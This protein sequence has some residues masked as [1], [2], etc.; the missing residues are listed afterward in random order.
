[1]LFLPQSVYSSRT[2]LARDLEAGRLTAD[3]AYQQMLQL[4]PD[5][6][7]ALLGL[8]RLRRE[9]GDIAGAKEIFWQAART[10]PYVSSPYLALAKTFF[11]EPESLGLATALGE[12]GISHRV[13]DDSLLQDADYEKASL[14]GEALEKFKKLPGGAQNRLVVRAMREERAGEPEEIAKLLHPFRLLQQMREDGDLDRE[15]VDT[16]LREGPSLAPLLVGILRGWA[17]DLLGEKDDSA[18]ENALALLGETGSPANIPHL[19]EFVGLEH[20][21]ASGASFWALGRMFERY[22]EES[23]RVIRSIASGLGPAERLSIAE[24]IGR[25]PEFDPDGNL[26]AF[27]G[28]NLEAMPKKDRDSFFLALTATMAS[29]KGQNGVNLGR[30]LLLRQAALLSKNVRHECEDLLNEFTR[31]GFPTHT[32]QPS[33]ISVYDVCAGE[34]VWSADDEEEEKEFEGEFDNDDKL[35]PVLELVKRQALPARNEPCW[36]GSGKKYKKCHLD[37]DTAPPASSP[38]R[39]SSNAGSPT[40]FDSLRKRIGEFLGQALPRHD[41]ELAVKEMFNDGAPDQEATD[42]AVT[43]WILHDWVAPSLGHPIM[44]HFLVRNGARLTE[45]EREMVQAWAQSFMGLYEVQDLTE[46]VGIKI[47]DLILGETFFVHDVNLS[48]R[49]VRW[50]GLL[51]RVVP[52]ERGTEFAGAGLTVPR[53]SIAPLRDWMEED[54]AAASLE[55]REYLKRNWPRIRRQSLEISTKWIQSV[56]LSN[57]DREELLMSKAVYRIIGKTAVSEALRKC[58]ALQEDSSDETGDFF[59]WLNDEQTVLGNIRIHGTKL[60]LECNS[61]QRMERGKLLL[62]SLAG[63][64]LKHL[65]DEFITQEEL[66]RLAAELPER[67]PALDTIPKEERDAMMTQYLERHYGEWPDRKL[68]ALNGK[69]PR[70]SVRSVKGRRLVIEVLRDIENN[71]ER[72]RRAGDPFYDVTKIRAALGLEI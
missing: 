31:C 15:A 6:Y 24:Q 37:S 21:D 38:R 8:G 53:H 26:L 3:Q 16:I 47:K 51:A 39:S 46:G 72:K 58:P 54:R 4:D 17:Q 2:R 13:T 61:R 20:E 67:D 52:G 56:R 65:N 18:L 34:V 1:M 19:L 70:Q 63:D 66:R 41:F 69:T 9:T 25:H 42:V 11:E 10:Q 68:P 35:P 44:Q 23:V 55:W 5:D 40:E 33:S 12:L 28:E 62:A 29:A 30:A 60:V 71:E 14:Q 57:T 50:D 45:R 59:V 36:C 49:L 48:T 27:L 22:P 64:S 32:V 7:I 43:D